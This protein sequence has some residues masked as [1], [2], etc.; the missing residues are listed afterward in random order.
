M[1]YMGNSAQLGDMGKLSLKKIGKAVKKVA[2]VAIPVAT[3]AAG[4]YGG[5]VVGSK[6]SKAVLGSKKAKAPTAGKTWP[7]VDDSGQ[8]YASMDASQLQAEAARLQN[9]IASKGDKK[10][11]LAWKL[12]RV[13]QYLATA[14]VAQQ[15]AVV[16]TAIPRQRAVRRQPALQNGSSG[17]AAEIAVAAGQSGADPMAILRA[18]TQQSQYDTGTDESAPVEPATAGDSTMPK[19][20]MLALAGGALFLL[21]RPAKKRH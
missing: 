4:A 1:A 18:T 12:D 17:G 13:A 11:E 3:A 10:G 16:R 5:A 19:G 6:L 9:K 21:V 15:A 20:V 8:Q 2:K 7:E 14:N